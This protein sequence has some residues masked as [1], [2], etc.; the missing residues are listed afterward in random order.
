VSVV[1]ILEL[2]LKSSLIAGAG[3]ALSAVLHRRPAA[4]RV[5]ILRATVCLLIALP[6]VMAIAPGLPLALLPAVAAAEAIAASPIAWADAVEPVEG[7]AL[8]GSILWPSG[9]DLVLWAWAIG[10]GLVLGRFALGVWTLRR[11]TRDGQGV[12]AAAWTAPLERISAARRPRLVASAA[13][14]APLSWGIPPGVVLIGH[15]QLAR[16]ETAR[17]VLAHELA[18]LRR[19]DWIFLVMSRMALSLFWFNPLVWGL[20][21][22]L[23]ARSEEAAD[24]EAVGELDRKSYARALIDLA[25]EFNPPAAL[26]MAGPAETLNR[27]IACIMKTSAPLRRRPVAMALTIGALIGV[28][29]PISALELTPRDQPSLSAPLAPLA[30][31]DPV[32][33]V[34][35]VAPPAPAPAADAVEPADAA[36]AVDAVAPVAAEVDWFEGQ[37]AY[38][39]PPPPPPPPPPVPPVPPAPPAP[40]VAMMAPPAPPA[41]PVPAVRALRAS[42]E[43]DRS[44]ALTQ[45]ER[46]ALVEARQA[47]VEARIQAREFRLD[48]QRARAEVRARAANINAEQAQTRAGIAR[49]RAERNVAGARVN[50]T[51]GAD[52]MAAGAARLREQSALLRDPAYRATRIER[53]RERGQTVTD[54]E[55][56]AMSPRL[57][58]RAV[59]LERRAVELRERAA[60]QPS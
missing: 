12:A 18:H 26:G 38:P 60:R 8:S 47:A 57:E 39:V 20:H 52:Q 50:M 5:D 32:D 17:A 7:V 58:T 54:A 16:P 21:A 49:E 56:Q 36:A 22:A 11:W 46:Q 27:R 48:A 44:R 29:T 23:S 55:L 31:L 15:D 37:D 1:L 51:R 53:A 19:G 28:A 24:A 4:D 3:L 10:A 42:G 6:A 59:Q 25:T 9:P 41:P 13:V 43:I 34:D 35:S 14:S 33:A 30:A 2:L 45:A 40:H